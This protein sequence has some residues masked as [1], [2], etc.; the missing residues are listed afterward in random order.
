MTRIEH[1][2]VALHLHRHEI[3]AEINRLRNNLRDMDATRLQ[4]LDAII[5]Q[6][7]PHMRTTG[8]P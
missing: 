1:A 3:D 4:R 2:L 8:T 5:A 7:T 6:E